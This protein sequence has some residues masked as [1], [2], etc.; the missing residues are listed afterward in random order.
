M[1]LIFYIEINLLKSKHET[2]LTQIKEYTKFI[3]PY[4]KNTVELEH[5]KTLSCI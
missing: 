2:T 5:T 4:T 3:A 1:H